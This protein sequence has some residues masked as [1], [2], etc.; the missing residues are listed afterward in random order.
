[1]T[2][3]TFS[4]FKL[5]VSILG[6]AWISKCESPILGFALIFMIMWKP[7]YVCSLFFA[8]CLWCLVM[9]SWPLQLL[10]LYCRGKQIRTIG[11]L[12][13]VTIWWSKYH[14]DKSRAHFWIV[15][16]L[17]TFWCHIF[18]FFILWL[19]SWQTVLVFIQGVNLDES[20]LHNASLIS[21]F[22]SNS[23]LNL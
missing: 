4:L 16:F 21:C 6:F 5:I 8:A 23:S 3:R 14:F 15:V 13:N 19:W 2:Y 17:F 10:R 22:T 11:L 1:M 12:T 18:F 9:N 20:W 7:L